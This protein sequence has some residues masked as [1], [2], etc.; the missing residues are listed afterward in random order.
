MSKDLTLLET[1][2]EARR[3]LEVVGVD[4]PVLDARMLVEMG[5]G[6]ERIE[7]LT[8]PYR[9]IPAE[10]WEQI[11]A[12]LKRR[13]AREPM[14]HIVGKRAFWKHDF[15]TTP[16]VLTP[17]PETEALVRLAVDVTT[18]DQELDVLDL[19][20]GSGAILLSVLH[21]REGARGLGL[22]HSIEAIAVAQANAEQLGLIG[23]TRF[24][25]GQWEAAD[26]AYDLVLSNPPYIRS[27]D[28]PLLEPEVF[29]YEPHLAL[30]GGVDGL[31]AYR[32]IT[33]I[34]PSLLKPGGVY[35]L[36][37]GFGQAEAV[38]ALLDDAGLPPSEVIKDLQEIPRVVWGR[39]G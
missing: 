20:V 32:R 26:G 34:L 28:I 36:E 2:K 39:G 37:L 15:V 30:D 25:H 7:I 14:S 21:E 24:H 13:E 29:R 22:D 19:G 23:R 1:W 4:T 12:L 11:E 17:R 35:A 10:A 31:D 9:A 3:R 18:P 27:N 38:W 33:A 6:V 5:A 8:D 16:S